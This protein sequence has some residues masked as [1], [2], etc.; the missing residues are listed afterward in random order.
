MGQKIK[1]FE[2]HRSK[3]LSNKCGVYAIYVNGHTYIGS[4]ENLSRRMT[5]HRLDIPKEKRGCR[6]LH[7]LYNNYSKDAFF[8]EI[9]E[10]CSSQ[11]RLEREKYYIQ[12]LN[13]DCN[14]AKDPQ[15]P[16]IHSKKVYQ[17]DTNGNYV[18]EFESVA[19]AARK[20]GGQ[21]GNISNAAN[22]YRYA[23]SSLWSYIKS[24]HYPHAVTTKI[25]TKCVYMY[26]SNSNELV[27][28]FNSIA[29]A[30]KYLIGMYNPNCSFDS[31]CA[32]ISYHCKHHT[33]GYLGFVFNFIKK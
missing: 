12:L 30:A 13:A 33:N 1:L 21:E 27:Q 8:Y 6:L 26:K 14:T 16:V 20:V 29:D 11:E 31:I 2:R 4:S 28:K 5:E 10:F 32:N 24:K 23:Y 18:D 22:R 17:Y 25:K 19:S 9:L 3:N 7:E 15:H